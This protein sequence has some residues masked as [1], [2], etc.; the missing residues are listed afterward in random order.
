MYTIRTM[1]KISPRGLE[2]LPASAFTVGDDIA[3]PDAILVRSADL[4]GVEFPAS[5]KAIARAGAGVNNIPVD[6][7]GG[8]GIVVF[9]TPG[10]NANSVKELTIA[11]MLL[12]SRGICEG[13][14]WARENAGTTGLEELVEKEK[15]RFAGTELSG[16]TLGVVGLGAIGVMVANAA[17]ALGMRVIGYDPYI[18]VDS[19]WGLSREV[20]RAQSIDTLF[21]E[22][23]FITLHVPLNDS[24]RG[25]IG[26]KS[27]KTIK[28]GARLLNLARGPLVDEPSVL[29]A[30]DEGRLSRYVTDFPN[31]RVAGHPLVIA[32]PH[33]G[34]STEEAEENCAIMAARQVREYLES[35]TIRNSVNFPE[36]QLPLG[37]HQRVLIAN[38]NIPNMVGQVTTILARHS[39]NILDM[40]N[41]HRGD[42]AYNIIDIEGDLG[43]DAVG[44]LRQVEGVIFVRTIPEIG[45]AA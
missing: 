42:L 13:L 25:M 36:C 12:A 44:Q 30:L 15:K 6:E 11:G 45:G 43:A 27:L 41:R 24:T 4:H 9:N 35:G 37:A 5:L 20:E 2:L 19:A 22:S 31:E 21:A 18:S 28:K 16:K 33:L 3:E 39:I 8:R 32:I 38:R 29:A 26:P 40:L 7:C 14:S 1:N 23:D 34:A 17:V 10:A